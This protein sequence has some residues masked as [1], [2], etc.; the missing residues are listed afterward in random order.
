MKII[1]L[2]IESKSKSKTNFEREVLDFC[3]VHNVVNKFNRLENRAYIICPSTDDSA[4][5]RASTL[6]RYQ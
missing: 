3:F 1:H 6:A 4:H 5:T 2:G